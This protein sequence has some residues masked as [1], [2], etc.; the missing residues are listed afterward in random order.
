MTDVAPSAYAEPLPGGS[1]MRDLRPRHAAEMP[2]ASALYLDPRGPTGPVKVAAQ[3]KQPAFDQL[4]LKHPVLRFLA[5]DDV[6]IVVAHKLV[7]ESGHCA[8]W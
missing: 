7:P 8:R 2:K 5:L 4:D 1:G 3:R 6:N